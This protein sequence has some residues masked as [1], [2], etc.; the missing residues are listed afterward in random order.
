MHRCTAR[1][2]GGMSQRLKPG[3]AT[4]APGPGSWVLPRD[5]L[6]VRDRRVRTD[7]TTPATWEFVVNQV[8]IGGDGT[9]PG[10]SRPVEPATQRAPRPIRCAPRVFLHAG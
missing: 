5:D 7:T 8:A 9:T 6:R 4:C 2:A 10:R 1:A 3:R